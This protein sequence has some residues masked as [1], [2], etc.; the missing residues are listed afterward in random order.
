MVIVIRNRFLPQEELKGYRVFVPALHFVGVV[1]P[2]RRITSFCVHRMEVP[3]FSGSRRYRFVIRIRISAVPAGPRPSACAPPSTLLRT[4]RLD[5]LRK[6]A[7]SQPLPRSLGERLGF[8]AYGP[9]A[10]AWDQSFR[11]W[12]DSCVFFSKTSHRSKEYGCLL[13]LM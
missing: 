2:A 8:S 7:C 11:K 5:L 10:V 13:P 4:G 6:Y 3:I 12:P 9:L 1:T